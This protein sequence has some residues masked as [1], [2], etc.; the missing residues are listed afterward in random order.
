MSKQPFVK[1]HDNLSGI[2]ITRCMNTLPVEVR[3][4]LELCKIYSFSF[5]KCS[6]VIYSH[7]YVIFLQI[8]KKTKLL[9]MRWF[10][11]FRIRGHHTWRREF[12]T[13]DRS[14]TCIYLCHIVAIDNCPLVWCCILSFLTIT[15]QTLLF[16]AR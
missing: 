12:P 9:K 1:T 3:T 10:P 13:V 5:R 14:E 16:I 6:I 8:N 4:K 7:N 11:G 15:T 2:Y